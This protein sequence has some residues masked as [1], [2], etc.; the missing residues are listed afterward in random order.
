MDQIVAGI[1]QQERDFA[2]AL[3]TATGRLRE[4]LEMAQQR[5][6]ASAVA[7]HQ[8]DPLAGPGTEVDATQDRRP[9]GDLLPDTARG[10]CSR[11]VGPSRRQP[12]KPGW[13]LRRA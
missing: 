13:T 10:D 9:V 3:D 11:P 6:L 8:R 1:L 5:R 2:G 4:P 12:A 7:A